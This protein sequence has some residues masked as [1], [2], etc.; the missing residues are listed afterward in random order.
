MSWLLAHLLAVEAPVLCKPV[1]GKKRI[2]HNI[3]S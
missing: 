1:V 2:K 3:I